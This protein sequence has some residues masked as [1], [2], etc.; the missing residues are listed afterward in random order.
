M[1]TLL[2]FFFPYRIVPKVSSK[3]AAALIVIALQGS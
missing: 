1:L 2:S 3:T